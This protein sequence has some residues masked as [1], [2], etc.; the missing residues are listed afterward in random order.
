M[1]DYGVVSTGFS[2]KPLSVILQEIEALNRTEFGAGVIQTAESPLGQL[3]GVYA[4]AASRMWELAEDVYQSYD[5]DQAEGARLETLGRIRL[6]SRAAGEIDESYRQAITN[7]GQARI[8]LQDLARAVAS[9][10]GVTYSYVW[11]NS[12]G[13]VDGNGMPP[14]S[15][16]IA[17]TGGDDDEIAAAIREYVVPGVTIYGSTRIESVLEGFCR[18]FRILRPV[19]VPVVLT[20]NVRTFTDQMG[21]PPPAAGAIEAALL[22]NLFVRNGDDISSYRIRSVI[23]NMFANVEVISI[24]T[25]RADSNDPATSVAAID[26]IERASLSASDLTITVV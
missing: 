18:T 22:S 10:A 2:R 16:C 23:E 24:E 17:A 1:T 4:E 12:D 11:V 20:V 26:F 13:A 8:D 19:D 6:S 21:C 15:I 25:R 14:A 9:I 5:P 3:N 7:A